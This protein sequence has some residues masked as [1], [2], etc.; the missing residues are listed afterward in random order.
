MTISDD[1]ID[2]SL[3]SE[4]N[5]YIPVSTDQ[6]AANVCPTR[7]RA[8][9]QELPAGPVYVAGRHSRACN[10]RDE[11]RASELEKAPVRTRRARAPTTVCRTIRQALGRRHPHTQAGIDRPTLSIAGDPCTAASR[12]KGRMTVPHRNSRTSPRTRSAMLAPSAPSVL[13]GG[14][15]HRLCKQRARVKVGTRSAHVPTANA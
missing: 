13:P 11:V 12:C 3:L 5:I 2:R 8:P 9:T 4:S 1:S 10:G 6:L 15:R 7:A 14:R